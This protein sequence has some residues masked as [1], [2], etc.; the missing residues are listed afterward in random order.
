M[1]S[2][3][4]FIMR[5][6]LPVKTRLASRGCQVEAM[7]KEITSTPTKHRVAGHNYPAY[8]SGQLKTNAETILNLCMV[9]T[10]GLILFTRLHYQETSDEM[11]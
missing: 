8:S 10:P 9:Y 2:V 3:F 4:S 6:L 5:F 11:F 7:C 1:H